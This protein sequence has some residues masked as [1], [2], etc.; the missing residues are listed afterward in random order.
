MAH[1]FEPPKRSSWP[2]SAAFLLMCILLA[3]GAMR[4]DLFP[5]ASTH[6][7]P[8]LERE[9]LPLAL[10][11]IVATLFAIL[12]KARWPRGRQ[13]ASAIMIG[14]GLFV[15][16][17]VL[18]H[19]AQDWISA[20]TR[21]TLF[22]LTPVFAVILEPHIDSANT[23][24]PGALLS[25][26]AAV[27]GALCIFPVDLPSSIQSAIAVAAIV[28]AAACIAAT[29]CFAARSSTT[30]SPIAP[31]AAIASA[32][33]AIA[34]LAITA[35]TNSITLHGLVSSQD[36]AWSAIVTVPGLLLL[37]WLMPRISAARITTRYLVAPLFAILISIALNR[38]NL[39]LRLFT[40]L[41]LLAAGA[42]RLLYA[43]ANKPHSLTLN[44]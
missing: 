11:A 30:Q 29:S 27:A 35:L 39:D 32:A 10:L 19:L 14:I 5:A 36:L 16:P 20:Y 7:A 17:A 43:P 31:I 1:P 34:L 41:I 13:L 18:A 42:A 2:T 3:I 15:V 25:S 33:S 28:L 8:Q 4:S 23:Q 26:I 37:F 22:C 12:R 24:S 40:G 6:T 9:A 38:P 44:Q 21:V